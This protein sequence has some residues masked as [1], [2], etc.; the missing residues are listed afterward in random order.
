MIPIL[1]LTFLLGAY[2]SAEEQDHP[3]IPGLHFMEKTSFQYADQVEIF[4]Y[5][6]GARL[7]DV[8]NSAR[9]LV[10]PEDQEEI[11]CPD[12][13]IITIRR[14]ENSVYMA[15]TAVMALVDSI[16][17]LDTIGFS[18]LTADGWYVENARKAME[19]G[20]IL[21]A[22]KY[23]QPDY[24]LLVQNNCSLAVESTM[25]LHS[26]KVKEMLENLGIPVFIDRSSYETH[27]LGR[28]EWVKVYG[29]LLGRE[30]E[31]EAFF[32]KEAAVMEELADFPNTGKTVAFFYINADGSVVVRR[33]D[34]YIPAM[35]RIAGGQYALDGMANL[36]DSLRSSVPVTMED[37]YLCAGDADYL[38]YNGSIEAP[39]RT[40][41]ELT[42]KSELFTDFKA[43]REG[44]VWYTDRYLYQATD[45]T[46]ELIR[47]LHRM[48]TE[49]DPGEM[50]FLQ[51]AE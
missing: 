15:A 30:E 4:R 1:I 45:R 26:P 43:V 20:S 49:E 21:F 37:F 6:G 42:A 9:Y 7:I 44:N 39:V 34:D 22:G 19:D 40:M 48:L 14:P 23:S 51:R 8:H 5:E 41:E 16:D 36:E 11:Q 3:E 32:R 47:D 10:L 2:A 17:A 29:A 28:T 25:I 27:P 31:A 35:I 46:G 13:E 33:P 38:V 50:M 24:E 18:S 12:P